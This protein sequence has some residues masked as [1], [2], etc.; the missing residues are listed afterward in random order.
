M[1]YSPVTRKIINISLTD[2]APCSHCLH[3][4]LSKGIKKITYST[5]DNT[6][7]TEKLIKLFTNGITKVSSGY[8]GMV[9]S[10]KIVK[11]GLIHD[12]RIN[13]KKKLSPRDKFKIDP[14]W[15]RAGK[16]PDTYNSNNLKKRKES[17]K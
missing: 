6:F 16:L 13:N 10:G 14:D 2:S 1:K 9:R 7:K 11:T 15:E 4:L 3:S 12:K 8:K 5:D 17:K